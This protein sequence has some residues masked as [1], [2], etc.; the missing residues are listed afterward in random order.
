MAS[1]MKM[2]KNSI[3]KIQSMFNKYY[4]DNNLFS[5]ISYRAFTQ[6]IMLKEDLYALCFDLDLKFKFKMKVVEENGYI[7][8]CLD[9]SQPIP[10]SYN[11][12][13][14][15]NSV[16]EQIIMAAYPRWGQPN[17]DLKRAISS[18]LGYKLDA[19]TVRRDPSV[20][21]DSEPYQEVSM[22]IDKICNEGRVSVKLREKEFPNLSDRTLFPLLI[23]DTDSGKMSYCKDSSATSY[24]QGREYVS[25]PD[26][27]AGNVRTALSETNIVM[28]C[29]LNISHPLV[30][31]FY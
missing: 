17:E 11:P 2:Y 3:S 5:S 24:R 30:R 6:R 12:S 15:N 9:L 19:E 18:S 29:D 7:F 4:Q 20:I 13:R 14:Y 27:G 10:L 21:V 23:L 16:G 28:Y 26:V 22:A 8:F 25:A 1:K 31:S